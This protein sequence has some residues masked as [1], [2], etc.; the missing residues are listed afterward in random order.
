MTKRVRASLWHDAFEPSGMK[1]TTGCALSLSNSV[2]LALPCPSTLRANSMTATCPGTYQTQYDAPQRHAHR[3]VERVLRAH[4]E[5]KAYAEEWLLRLTC[6]LGGEDLALDGARA[7][8]AWHKDAVRQLDTCPP[9]RVLLLVG[10]VLLPHL[11]GGRMMAGRPKL[12]G[13]EGMAIARER[14]LP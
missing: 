12:A 13:G 11:A 7:E 2:E 14:V 5:T 3:G 9:R 8:A 1:M 10:A 4:L 6:I